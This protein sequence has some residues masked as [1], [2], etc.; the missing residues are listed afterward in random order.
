MAKNKHKRGG[1]LSA[2]LS[3]VLFSL[4]GSVER[5]VI[6]LMGALV[7]VALA[8]TF[9]DWPDGYR[10][11]DKITRWVVL[12][13]CSCI[14]STALAW[15]PWEHQKRAY[16]D[17][18]N[19]NLVPMT[20][21]QRVDFTVH[22]SGEVPLEAHATFVKSYF[23]P[24][25]PDQ[26]STDEIFEDF[27]TEFQR[28]EKENK[29]VWDEDDVPP[30]TYNGSGQAIE[31]KPLSTEDLQDLM[32]G[33]KLYGYAFF[34]IQY[35]DSFGQHSKAFCFYMQPPNNH[36]LFKTP[37]KSNNIFGTWNTCRPSDMKRW[38]NSL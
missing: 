21:P 27:K 17:V 19:V 25:F 31:G 18:L 5:P 38:E 2:L 36:V 33:L 22:N 15:Y 8:Y 24:K 11:A 30:D 16:V 26:S 9:S 20:A 10:G 29:I 23:V 14:A 7:A 3:I 34:V 28:A 37:I 1:G 35:R 13:V 6:F 12:I 4:G 32:D